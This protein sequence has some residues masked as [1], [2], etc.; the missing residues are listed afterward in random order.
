MKYYG[1]EPFDLRL[2]VLR[3]LR[4]SPVIAGLTLLG[5]VLFGGG[6]YV[7]NVVLQGPPL[8]EATSVY[9]V[10]YAVQEEKDV[11]NVY[12]N[13]ASWNTYL[14]S[15]MFQKMLRSCLAEQ[16]E[17]GFAMNEQELA[18]TLKAALTTDLRMPS[19]IVTT[20]SPEKS[21]WIAAAV[22]KVMTGNLAEEIREVTSIRVLDPGDAAV[23]VVPDVRVG[24]AVILSAVLSC[25]FCIVLFL[26]KET[27]DDNIWL[28]ASLRRRYGLKTVGTL[29]DKVLSE[30]M[31]YF[32]GRKQEE[33]RARVAVCPVQKQLNPAEI[34]QILRQSCPESVG[35]DWFPVQSPLNDPQVC[36]TLRE[37]GGILLVVRAGSHAGKQLE[38]VLDYLEQQDCRVTAAI[39]WKADERLLRWYYWKTEG[40]PGNW[41]PKKGA[42]R[43]RTVCEE[44]G[45]QV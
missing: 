23:E 8:Y 20:D 10:E 6:Y 29:D 3:M 45:R 38:Y 2:T 34:L 15:E 21:M 24:R 33:G 14:Q 42:E 1:N 4:R 13:E 36:E 17:G 9:R 19:T 30:N 5:T 27:G 40:G 41:I 43:H 22:E 31:K 25:F 11:G 39:L 44:K 37:A 18:G 28:P 12:I 35:E 26:L 16:K 7:K 32:F